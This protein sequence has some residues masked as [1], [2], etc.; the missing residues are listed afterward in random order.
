MKN[1][2]F[3][4]RSSQWTIGLITMILVLGC[5]GLQSL[6]VTQIIE[7]TRVIPVTQIVQATKFVPVTRI[8]RVTRI[9]EVPQVTP[10][11]T[12]APAALEPPAATEAPTRLLPFSTPSQIKINNDLLVW[13]DFEDDFLNSGMVTD[14]SGNGY[15]ARINGSVDSSDG[16]SDGHA[17]FFHGD[18]FIFMPGNPAAGRTTLSFSLWFRTDHPEENYKLAS[19]AWW[20]GGPGSGWVIGTHYPELWS[21]DTKSIF[22]DNRNNAD[23]GFLTNA[24]NQE[25]VTYDG[26]WVKEYT[27]GQLVNNWPSTGAPIGGGQPMAIGAWPPFGFNFQ[28]SLDEFKIFTRC[29]T[30]KEV[31][32]FYQQGK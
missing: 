19:A 24:W 22:S 8:V 12:E 27:N 26:R 2:S 25:V 23:N 29:L 20:N 21:D 4:T 1:H 18:G 28:G 6:P 5:S 7:V 3:K 30:K 14:R 9:V 32:T 17:M 16:V 31:Q 11:A 15:A 10:A 13:Y